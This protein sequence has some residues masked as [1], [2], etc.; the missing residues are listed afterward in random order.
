MPPAYR[1]RAGVRLIGAGATNK[2]SCRFIDWH[3]GRLADESYRTSISMHRIL[4]H[5]SDRFDIDVKGVILLRL[6]LDKFGHNGSPVH[7]E[8]HSRASLASPQQH[9]HNSPPYPGR[10]CFCGK[11]GGEGAQCTIAYGGVGG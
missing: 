10:F 5:V 7:L 4:R 1:R 6:N 3:R 9:R 2:T 11:G 8:S